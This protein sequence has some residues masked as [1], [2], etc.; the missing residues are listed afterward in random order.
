[1]WWHSGHAAASHRLATGRASTARGSPDPNS[2]QFWNL[3]GSVHQELGQAEP[4][5][6]QTW[7]S[8]DSGLEGC[9]GYPWRPRLPTQAHLPTRPIWRTWPRCRGLRQCVDQ[10]P[11]EPGAGGGGTEPPLPGVSQTRVLENPA[12]LGAQDGG[13][14]GSQACAE[15]SPPGL[16]AMNTHTCAP[17]THTHTPRPCT[18][19]VPTQPEESCSGPLPQVC[20]SPSPR[21]DRADKRPKAKSAGRYP[22]CCPQARSTR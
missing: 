14:A 9:W 7:G 12:H 4:S 22:R 1:M 10:P 21:P 20:R 13:R 15:K 2:G 8:P 16:G 3:W 17:H 11:G 18:D 5:P 19:L 6:C